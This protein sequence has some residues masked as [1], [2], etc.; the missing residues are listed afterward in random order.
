VYFSPEIQT[1]TG[2]FRKKRRPPTKEV[3]HDEVTKSRSNAEGQKRARG[4]VA[5]REERSGGEGI[6][7]S[8]DG[9]GKVVRLGQGVGSGA[10]N[11][12]FAS[13]AAL[14]TA[15]SRR[16]TTPK[17]RSRHHTCRESAF[18]GTKHMCRHTNTTYL[19]ACVVVN[20]WFGG[21]CSLSVLRGHAGRLGVNGRPEAARVATRSAVDARSVVWLAWCGRGSSLIGV[22]SWLAGP[23]R[24]SRLT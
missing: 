13:V 2:S 15:L 21:G 20:V 6:R 18:R 17:C 24:A 8:G 16:S 3:G 23:V 11:G 4:G 1:H 9:V 10:V 22:L 14:R 5:G 12:T 19:D 7:T